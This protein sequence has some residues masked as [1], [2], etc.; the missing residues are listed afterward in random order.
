MEP[1][2]LYFEP[3]RS[4]TMRRRYRLFSFVGYVLSAEIDG[5]RRCVLPGGGF[6]RKRMPISSPF[7]LTNS[8]R[9]KVRPQGVRSKKNSLRFSPLTEWGTT[10]LA[11]VAETS[12]SVQLRYQVPSIPIMRASMPRSKETRIFFRSPYTIVDSH[13]SLPEVRS[14][15]DA[16]TDIPAKSISPNQSAFERSGSSCG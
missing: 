11:P 4:S 2:Y 1:N 3:P 10:S 5:G 12:A 13:A 15:M 9:R 14:A 6:F 8:Q 16:L 7:T